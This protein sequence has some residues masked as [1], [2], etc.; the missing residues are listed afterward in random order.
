MHSLEIKVERLPCLALRGTSPL[1]TAD[2]M[3]NFDTRPNNTYTAI[4]SMCRRPGVTSLLF[5]AG[6]ADGERIGETQR[7]GEDSQS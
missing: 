7:G 4:P 1:A 3:P 5:S 2:L 6:Y